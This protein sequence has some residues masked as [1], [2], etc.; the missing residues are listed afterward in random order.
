M[1]EHDDPDRKIESDGL[2]LACSVYGKETAPVVIFAH[3]GGQTRYAW[4]GAAKTL[5]EDGYRSVALD[6]RGHGDSEWSKNRDY[7]LEAFGRDLIA[8]AAEFELEDRAPHIVGASLGGLGAIV[9]AGILKPGIFA[10][11]TLVDITPNMEASGVA[12]IVGFMGEHSKDGF[13]SLDEAADVI[14]L[15]LPNRP[16]PKDLEGLRKNLRQGQDGRWR[17]HWDPAFI[18]SVM[19]RSA[20]ERVSDLEQAVRDIKVP[21]HLVRGRMSEL[22]SNASV[23]AFKALAPGAHF[24]D[25]ADAQHMVAGDKNDL[26]TAAVSDFLRQ[27]SEGVNA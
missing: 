24:T 13:S 25:V 10:S 19:R 6:L 9:A 18:Q 20:N 12:K 8:V 23:E 1:E 14:S 2:I 15:Y 21:I 7:S 5:G 22:V 16:R 27:Q 4:K 26:F 17:W 11:V 3:G